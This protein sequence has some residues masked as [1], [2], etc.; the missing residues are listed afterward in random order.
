MAASHPVKPFAA[1]R[2]HRSPST[3]TQLLK[4][5]RSRH[6]PVAADGLPQTAFINL[7]ICA[8]YDI[9]SK[10]HFTNAPTAR[11]S[12]LRLQTRYP[13]RYRFRLACFPSR[14]FHILASNS[15]K[16]RQNSGGFRCFSVSRSV[17]N[18]GFPPLTR[19]RL[20]IKRCKKQR[21]QRAGAGVASPRVSRRGRRIRSASPKAACWR[22]RP[23]RARRNDR[24]AP[25]TARGP[26]RPRR[27]R[28]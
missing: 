1:R 4:P 10:C 3:P 22:T 19:C 18:P 12:R 5:T 8:G 7:I 20:L 15:G 25:P 21:E 27:S 9:I 17:G 23:R 13:L 16:Q 28:P 26:A 2:D 14:L 6:C 11:H 24:R